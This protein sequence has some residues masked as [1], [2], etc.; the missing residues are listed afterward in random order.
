MVCRQ[1]MADVGRS[2]VVVSPDA[3]PP[4]EVVYDSSGQAHTAEMGRGA[5]GLIRMEGTQTILDPPEVA[6]KSSKAT[7]KKPMTFSFGKSIR[8]DGSPRRGLFLS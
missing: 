7:E 4:P 2:I 3:S 8:L 6:D 5:K 1:L